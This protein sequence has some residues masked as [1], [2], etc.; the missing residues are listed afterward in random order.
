MKKSKITI[1]ILLVL[2]L[3][4]CKENKEPNKNSEIKDKEI[5][6]GTN[7]TNQEELI[8]EIENT[9]NEFSNALS[10]F[11]EQKLNE[12]PFK[13][14]WTAGQVA[15]HIIKSN[16]GIITQLLNGKTKSTNRAIDEQVKIIQEIFRGEEK[17]KSAKALEPTEK[18]HN[19]DTLLSTLKKQ[20]EQQIQIVKEK[21]LKD[22]ILELEFPPSPD[23]LTRIEWVHLM[24]EHAKRHKNQI[25]NINSKLQ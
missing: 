20:K 1:I 21:N 9:H 25:D 18:S 12:I 5:T 3:T 10:Q 23:G 15:E 13:G 22:L 4:S 14:S 24:I 17:M 16:K 2:T 7:N 6:M 19:L 11:T 8:S